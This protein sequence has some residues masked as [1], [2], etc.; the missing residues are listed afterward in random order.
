MLQDFLA[1]GGGVDVGVDFGGA[2]GLMA[3]QGLDDA[4]VGAAFEQGCCKRVAQR[5]GRDG[6][7]DAGLL[8][9][10]F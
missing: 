6:L 8:G 7:R 5:V 4:Q 3:Q 1:Q 2:D 9:L 10:P